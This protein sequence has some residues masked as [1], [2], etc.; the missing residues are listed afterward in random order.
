VAGFLVGVKKTLAAI[1]CVIALAV[2]AGDALAATQAQK[3]KVVTVSRAATGPVVDVDRWG[4]LQLSIKVKVTTTTVGTK[5]TKSFKVTDV[6]YPVYPNHTDRSAYISRQ[7][8][9]L[10]TQ[11]VLQLKGSSIQL[12]SGAT[13][14]S[15]AFV[16]AVRGALTKAG[17]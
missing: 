2:P 4:Q 3:K 5:K 12:V 15:Y 14:T 17:V 9:P 11:E 1:V 6:T 8:L 10:L 13:D 16:E 7:A